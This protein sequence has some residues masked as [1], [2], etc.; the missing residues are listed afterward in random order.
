[1]KQESPELRPAVSSLSSQA[2]PCPVLA[3]RGAAAVVPADGVNTTRALSLH[4]VWGLGVD[5]D[6]L[7][8]QVSLTTPESGF[9]EPSAWLGLYLDSIP[10]L[11]GPILAR[12]L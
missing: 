10:G 6:A 11:L 4:L 2:K 1:M 3:H 8:D 7:L 9:S 12:I 5:Q